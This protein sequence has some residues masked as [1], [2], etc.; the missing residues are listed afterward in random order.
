M[1]HDTM[2]FEYNGQNSACGHLSIFSD[3]KAVRTFL[4][5]QKYLEQNKPQI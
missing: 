3:V 2:D 1:D 5:L 4:Y